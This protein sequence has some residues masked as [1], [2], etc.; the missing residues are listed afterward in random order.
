MT[1]LTEGEVI[2]YA[3]ALWHETATLRQEAEDGTQTYGMYRIPKLPKDLQRKEGVYILSPDVIHEEKE[4]RSL[5]LTFQ[6]QVENLPLDR[7]SEDVVT[8]EIQKVADKIERAAAIFLAR[9]DPDRNLKE[10]RLW[11]QMVTPLSVEI[12]EMGP[13]TSADPAQRFCWKSFDVDLDGCGWLEADGIPTVFG[14]EYQQ[15]VFDVETMS[16]RADGPEGPNAKLRY[17]NNGKWSWMASDDFTARHMPPMTATK[18]VE[19]ASMVWLDDY[20]GSGMIYL[21]ALDRAGARWQIGPVGIGK[22]QAQGKLVWKGPNMFGRVSAFLTPGNKT[23]QRR[24]Q[25]HYMAYLQELLTITEQ[26]NVI[27]STLASA[28]RNAAAPRDYIAAEPESMK[29]YLQRN[30]GA[31]PPP[32]SWPDD[33]S[34]PVLLGEIKER[35][36]T[37]DPHF[38]K[39]SQTLEARR[40]RYQHGAL[41]TLRDPQVLKDSTATGII[42]GWDSS[43]ISLSPILGASDRTDRQKV[44]AWEH[45]I[46]MIAEKYGASYAK[47]T[48]LATGAEYVKGKPLTAGDAAAISADD[49][50]RPHEWRVSTRSRTQAQRQAMLQLAIESMA[51]L[52]DGRPNIGVYDDLF[53][54]ADV[55]DK[56]ER[57]NQL[58][59]E[60][61]SYELDDSWLL[62]MAK[63]SVEHE[64]EVDSGERIPLSSQDPATLN[65]PGA[66]G[67]APPA[68]PGRATP[69]PS[70]EPAAP[71]GSPPR[72]GAN[73]RS[74]LTEPAKG[75]SGPQITAG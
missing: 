20:N 35:P 14:R 59:I 49:F 29:E 38:D 11:R 32:I 58:A 55:T 23:P 19:R 4:I 39:L 24:P 62:E 54:A 61:I 48:L 16:Q 2:E 70:G 34:S 18:Q 72:T 67:A 52:P 9:L 46:K 68:G 41:T 42:S 1:D 53:E 27:D 5:I 10:S 13:I 40:E 31:M 60:H 65:T 21:V 37:I 25:D 26:G 57:V 63:L 17:T 47:F 66:P 28:A 7:N 3:S 30:N 69:P 75:G 43:M 22:T 51:P 73:E 36:I 44:E 8:G 45:S 50:K 56:E 64:I 74:P 15:M 12:L 33:G 6:T 71:T